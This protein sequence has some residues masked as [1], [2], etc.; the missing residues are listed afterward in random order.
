MRSHHLSFELL[1]QSV[2]LSVTIAS[3]LL[4]SLEHVG[5]AVFMMVW[6]KKAPMRDLPSIGFCNEPLLGSK[7]AVCQEILTEKSPFSQETLTKT[8]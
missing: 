8:L 2:V 3:S 6:L 5:F 4:C 7:Y 1:Q